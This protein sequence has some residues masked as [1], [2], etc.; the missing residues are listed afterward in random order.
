MSWQSGLCE[1]EITGL[2]ETKSDI[3]HN[4]LPNKVKNNHEGLVDVG[5]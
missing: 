5:L 3:I 4:K 1:R 2:L